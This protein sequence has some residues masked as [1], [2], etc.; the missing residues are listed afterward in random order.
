[1]RVLRACRNKSSR[2]DGTWGTLAVAKSGALVA[3]EEGT[4]AWHV[5]QAAVLLLPR[6]QISAHSGPLVSL[7]GLEAW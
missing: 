4:P 1:M 5:H 6:S 7:A 3:L 2:E